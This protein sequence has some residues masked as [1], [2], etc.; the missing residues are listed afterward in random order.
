M[1]LRDYVRV[2]RR[3]WRWLALVLVL[4]IG[5]AVA[6][7]AM[8]TPI[9]RA[10]AQL[11]ISTSTQSDISDLVQGTSFTYRQVTTY[12]DMVTAPVVLE[13]VIDDMGLAEDPESLAARITTAVPEDTV[14]INIH[15]TGTEAQEAADIADAVAE[16]FTRTI[17]EL[18][19]PGNQG[20]SPVKAS[21]I[22][23]AKAPSAPVAPNPSRNLALG[24]SLGLMLGVAAAV[25]RDMVDT[26][27]TGPSDVERITDRP[28]IGGIIF[29][30]DTAL[31]PTVRTEDYAPRA[32]AFRA[33]RTNLQFID[34]A[35]RPRLLLITSSLPGE[36]KSTTTA[37][38]AQALAASGAP[39]CVVEADL[40][41]PK[42][43]EY[44]G[45]ESGAGLTSVLI[46]QATL[47]E[48]LQPYGENL[49]AL[50]SG[51]IP[52]NPSELL[53][54]SAM[55][56]LLAELAERFEYVVIDAPPLLPVTD[57]A[58]LSKIVDGTIVVVGASI[59]RRHQLSQ[60][61]STLA[62]VDAK[63][64][65]LLLN[66]LKVDATHTYG[67]Y[68]QEYSTPAP[69]E[70]RRRRGQLRQERRDRRERRERWERVRSGRA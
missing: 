66:R 52:P 8:T 41:R 16:Q 2:L 61:L 5:G 42:L 37:H 18:E 27:V 67:Y 21:V 3:R 58:V 6:A 23:P 56:A 17:A 9:Y 34:A 15:V 22:R 32:E 59:V 38:L 62:G 45:L 44:L 10:T 65:G 69:G 1:E 7:T 31:S 48:V 35:E 55:R 20:A 70:H 24:M 49:T 63:V 53:G 28:I 14:L 51:A 40:R 43:L 30:R 50:G 64:L 47:D 25:L 33:I 12:A 26:R 68:H 57:A 11:F 13:P 54:G 4:C 46:G 29:D 36:G 19:Q 60:A 39:V